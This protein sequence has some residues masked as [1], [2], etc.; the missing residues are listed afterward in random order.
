MGA[1]ISEDGSGIVSCCKNILVQRRL[2]QRE[3]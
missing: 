3:A 2:M 1:T